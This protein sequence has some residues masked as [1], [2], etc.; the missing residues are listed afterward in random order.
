[1]SMDQLPAMLKDIEALVTCESPSGD[2]AAIAASAD[3][4][5]RLGERLLNAKPERIG[6]HLGSPSSRALIAAL[7]TELT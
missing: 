4:V 3:L 5:A 2:P 7:I 6:A 1:M